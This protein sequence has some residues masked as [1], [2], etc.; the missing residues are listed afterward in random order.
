MNSLAERMKRLL[1]IFFVEAFLLANISLLINY[2]DFIHTQVEVVT[3]SY[4]IFYS[5]LPGMV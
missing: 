1:I 3:I 2:M 5:A 4:V